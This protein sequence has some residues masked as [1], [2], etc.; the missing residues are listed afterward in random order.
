LRHLSNSIRTSSLKAE[1]SPENQLMYMPLRRDS[2]NSALSHSLQSRI[3]QTSQD[4]QN[5]SPLSVI[6]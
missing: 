2:R 1:P 6:S 3:L 4:M 5:R